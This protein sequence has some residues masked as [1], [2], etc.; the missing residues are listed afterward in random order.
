VCRRIPQC[1]RNTT[2]GVKAGPANVV[3][4]DRHAVGTARPTRRR[5]LS[6]PDVDS[7]ISL[8]VV[9]HRLFRR[10]G[11]L[12][13]LGVAVQAVLRAL[14]SSAPHD[15]APSSGAPPP[16]RAGD[17]VAVRAAPPA[18]SAPPPA[19]ASPDRVVADEP[20]GA[21]PAA[22]APA[23]KAAAPAKKA[24]AKKAPA[25]KAAAQKAATPT[26]KAPTKKS[27]AKKAPAQKAAKKTPAKKAEPPK[28][29]G[30]T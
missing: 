20:P 4:P 2:A 27:A 12:V 14:R 30:D 19:P 7:G 9:S 23:K 28:P 26:K 22:E 17:G 24:P 29:D 3:L 16:T 10:L 25:K 1:C 18:R 11:L 8:V 6:R 5:A 13:L 15:A 21:A